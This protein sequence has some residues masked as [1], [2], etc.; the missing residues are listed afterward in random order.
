MLLTRDGEQFPV[1]L[2]YNLKVCAI[3]PI[4]GRIGLEYT[5]DEETGRLLVTIL[6][7]QVTQRVY[8]LEVS[9]MLNG[10]VA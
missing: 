10:S 7:R 3:S 2:A 8:G 9:G 6:A 1:A 4:G 5:L